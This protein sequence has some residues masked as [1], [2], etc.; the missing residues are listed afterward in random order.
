[1]LSANLWLPFVKRY[2]GG[3]IYLSQN[4][5]CFKSD[6]KSLV[7]LVIPLRVIQVVFLRHLYGFFL[8]FK[9]EHCLQSVEKIVD[10]PVSRF[11][12]QIVVVTETSTFQ[13]SHIHERDFFVQKISE[14][15]AKIKM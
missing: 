2:A 11:E 6:V 3:K 10:G 8:F 13:M 9:Q 14:L 1:M 12:N 4:Y 7:S 5:M 15:L